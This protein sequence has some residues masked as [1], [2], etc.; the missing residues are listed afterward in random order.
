MSGPENRFFESQG[1]RLHYA[2]WGNEDAP[3][4]TEAQSRG[5]PMSAL[6]Q[7]QTFRDARDMSALALKADMRDAKNKSLL[8]A[9]SGH[10]ITH[11]ITGAGDRDGR[12]V[13]PSSG[14][15]HGSKKHVGHP[16]PRPVQ[17]YRV[18]SW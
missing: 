6:G 2:D 1:L 18:Q 7:K 9:N 16:G 4:W 17:V 12:M 10:R 3:H 5:A 8:W 13:R 15:A 11:S 14:V